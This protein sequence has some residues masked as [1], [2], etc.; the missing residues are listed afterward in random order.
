MSEKKNKDLHYD[1]SG[2]LGGDPA[3]ILVCGQRRRGKSTWWLNYLVE[4]FEQKGDMFVWCRR[5]SVELSGGKKKG[6]QNL[7][8]MH[9][10][11]A[12]VNKFFRKK[13]TTEGN[14][15]YSNGKLCGQFACLALSG[16]TKGITIPPEQH[17]RNFLLDEFLIDT[18][19]YHYLNGNNDPLEFLKIVD[20]YASPGVDGADIHHMI[21]LSNAVT[22]ANP[23]FL[24]WEV[25]PF[26]GR[27]YRDDS[28]GVVVEMDTNEAFTEQRKATRF[29]KAVS[30]TLY[31]SY[32]IDNSFMLDDPK[33]IAKKPIWATYMYGVRFRSRTFGVWYDSKNGRLY[34]NNDV[35]PN[36]SMYCL[37][38]DD[39][40]INTLLWR[41]IKKS[42]IE[43]IVTAYQIGQLY[44]SDPIV[45]SFALDMLALFI[46]K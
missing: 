15:I 30:G 42:P 25:Q 3:V 18:P 10:F 28:R 37:T 14:N 4:Q 21:M 36:R 24:F 40:S 5:F 41:D 32:A 45:K 20:S 26:R 2:T 1:G 7:G 12:G 16:N 38:R 35:I 13:I 8:C 17:Y 19:T 29:G 23:Y 11:G 43:F 34:L 6:E 46:R 9:N 31:D 27:Y 39:M 33:F 22:F 44:F